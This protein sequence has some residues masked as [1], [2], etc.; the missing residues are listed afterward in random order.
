[1]RVEHQFSVV[2]VADKRVPAALRYRELPWRMPTEHHKYNK[3]VFDGG[4]CV[5][6]NST[7]NRGSAAV[8]Q[9]CSTTS[10]FHL[11]D[12]SKRMVST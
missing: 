3:W 7:E 1:M 4:L 12:H 5:S 11:I 9:K 2:A 8:E 10:V 6:I